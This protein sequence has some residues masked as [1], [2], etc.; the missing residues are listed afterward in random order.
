MRLH[1]FRRFLK[2]AVFRTGIFVC[3]PHRINDN[4]SLSSTQHQSSDPQSRINLKHFPDKYDSIWDFRRF[5]TG[6]V[7]H[8]HRSDHRQLLYS[9]GL[10]AEM[11]KRRLLR[12][13]PGQTD[14]FV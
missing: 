5:R 6:Y 9:Q 1:R 14:F 3:L 2:P 11:N 7:Q 10:R 12:M 13:H 4:R 8:L